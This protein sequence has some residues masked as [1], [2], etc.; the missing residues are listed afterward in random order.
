MNGTTVDLLG[1]RCLVLYSWSDLIWAD[2]FL[3][4]V[5]MPPVG[6]PQGSRIART[7]T[8]ILTM[9]PFVAPALGSENSHKLLPR[10][11]FYYVV[12]PP[13]GPS[14][15]CLFYPNFCFKNFLCSSHSIAYCW[16]TWHYQQWFSSKAP[17]TRYMRPPLGIGWLKRLFWLIKCFFERIIVTSKSEPNNTF[18]WI[19]PELKMEM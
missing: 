16:C 19:I 17:Q 14:C 18:C 8:D 2:K 5:L 7:H 1:H 10:I 6:N 4:M 13:A 15:C 9:R 3:A 12:A 11:R